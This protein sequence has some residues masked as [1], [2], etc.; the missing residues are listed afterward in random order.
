MIALCFAFSI[1]YTVHLLSIAGIPLLTWLILSSPKAS[2]RKIIGYAASAIFIGSNTALALSGIFLESWHCLLSGS[3]LEKSK[4]DVIHDDS[5]RSWVTNREYRID[6]CAIFIRHN[7]APSRIRKILP[8]DNLAALKLAITSLFRDGAWYHVSASQPIFWA[9]LSLVVICAKSEKVKVL[10]F[11]AAVTAFIGIW[12]I[13]KTPAGT[14]AA[15][16]IP[17]VNQLQI[18][19]FY[20]CF[21]YSSP[22]HG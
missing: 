18:D 12:V 19:R 16:Q 17:L 11:F 4:T 3:V 5:I 6:L 10:N 22:M 1:T 2:N 14:A 15:E 7:M 20:F 13:F 9:G 8:S 21:Q